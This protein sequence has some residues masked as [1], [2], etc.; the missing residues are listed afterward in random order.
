MFDTVVIWDRLSSRL[1]VSGAVRRVMYFFKGVALDKYM[2]IKIN[3]NSKNYN[4]H[5]RRSSK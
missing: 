3:L 5:T 1:P 4:I 2:K